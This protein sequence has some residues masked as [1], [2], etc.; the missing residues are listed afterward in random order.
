MNLDRHRPALRPGR[1]HGRGQAL[2]EFALVF[3]IFITMMMGI[4]E[5][6]FVFNAQLSVGHATRDSALIAAEAGNAS[7]A[8]CVILQQIENERGENQ[9]D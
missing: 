9:H 8:D 5:F 3:P 6:S 1:A 7:G 4:L 2:V